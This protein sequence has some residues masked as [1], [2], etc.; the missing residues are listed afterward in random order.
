[1]IVLKANAP[2]ITRYNNHLNTLV[3]N[4]GGG[5]RPLAL[6]APFGKKKLYVKNIRDK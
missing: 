5:R 6:K 1:M 3:K 2:L 4:S